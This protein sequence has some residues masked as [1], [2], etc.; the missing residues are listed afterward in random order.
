MP[1]KLRRLKR[2]PEL[3]NAVERVLEGL[4]LDHTPANR[5]AITRA[6]WLGEFR[7]ALSDSDIA[8]LRGRLCR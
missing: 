8:L 5:F 7:A 6:A 2:R 1:A 3:P 4:P